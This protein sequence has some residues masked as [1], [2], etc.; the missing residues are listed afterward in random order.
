M[1]NQLQQILIDTIREKVPQE[2]NLAV[3]LANKLNLGRESVYRRLRGEIYFTFDE[4]ALLS[5]ELG[6]SIDNIVGAKSGQNALFNIHMLQEGA[7]YLDIYVNKMKEYGRM[8][9]EM[10]EHSDLKARIS[11]NTLP[12]YL[13]IGHENLSRFRIYK[14]LHQNLKIGSNDKFADFELPEYITDTHKAFYQDIQKIPNVTVI[15][16]GNIF[17]SAAKDIAYF[18]KRGLLSEEDVQVL[19][20]ELLEII[21]TIEEAATEGVSK[22]GAR[23]SIYI[24]SVDLEASY[25]HFENDEQ[26]FS[27]VRV[28]SISAIDSNNEGLCRIQ[29]EWIESLKKYSI[30]ISKSGE[31]Q[32]YE[33]M[34]RQREIINNIGC[35]E[36][37]A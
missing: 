17:W 30:L 28:F 6:F 14:W 34:N 26:Q 27:Q 31:V 10:S 35:L 21:D 32:R 8:F 37:V 18:Q 20:S 19:Q 29:K 9:S 23:T 7:E 13:H 24:S 11:I 3:F 12:Y 16:D 2:H 5:Q 15:M 22:N 36:T 1:N 25:L 4:I 33:Y